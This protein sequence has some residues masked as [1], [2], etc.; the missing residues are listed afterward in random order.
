MIK[1]TF[2]ILALSVFSAMLGTGIIAPLMPIYAEELGATGIWIGV[3]LGAYSFSRALLMP[4]V[5]RFSDQRG[6]KIVLS[7]GLLFFAVMSLGYIW[8]GSVIQLTIVR[9]V[10]GVGSAMIIPVAKAYVGDLAPKGKEGTWMGYYNTSFFAGFGLGPLIGGFFTEQFGITYAF[11]AMGALSL[12]SFLSVAL[13]LP[14]MRIDKSVGK[15]RP[16]FK[17]MS[18]SPLFR[19][20]FLLQL[21]EGLGRTGFFAF[22]PIFAG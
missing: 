18:T 14:E 11:A 2:L 15:P 17:M 9:L 19:G 21:F 5:G 6:R 20:I 13:F 4:F 8:V 3:I 22:I 7:I 12:L 1:R 10:H 16:S